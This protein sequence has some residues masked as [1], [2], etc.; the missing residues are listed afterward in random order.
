MSAADAIALAVIV[1]IA[2]GFWG[3]CYGCATATTNAL[4]V[5]KR[6][7]ARW[8]EILADYKALRGYK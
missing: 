3:Y 7:D 4:A 6:V 8:R 1:G 5:L 2:C